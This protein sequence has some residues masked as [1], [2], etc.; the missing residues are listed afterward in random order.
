MPLESRIAS[1][2]GRR[3]AVALLMGGLLA[4]ALAIAWLQAR[5]GPAHT[6]R[7]IPTTIER[8]GP[9]TFHRPAGWLASP[10]EPGR[11]GITGSGISFTEP[12]GAQRKLIVVRLSYVRP[13][14]P[15][16]AARLFFEQIAHGPAEVWALRPR[17]RG[18]L[19]TLDGAVITPH[20]ERLLAVL[21]V[22]GQEYLGLSLSG[23]EIAPDD[24]PLLDLWMASV[25]DERFVPLRE[26][27]ALPVG[28]SIEAPPGLSA[29]GYAGDRELTRVLFHP[30]HDPRFGVLRFSSI[31]LSAAPPLPEQGT[32]AGEVLTNLVADYRQSTA[33]ERL[34]T[35]LLARYDRAVG[36]LPPAQA[37]GQFRVL[38]QSGYL[39]VLRSSPRLGIYEA[40]WG[41]TLAPEQAAQIE[42]AA[43]LDPDDRA[44]DAAG[45][46]Q[47]AAS[48]LVQ[49]LV[50]A[51][52]RPAVP[53][54]PRAVN[55]GNPEGATE[56]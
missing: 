48:V 5:G 35:H 3:A 50:G 17:R 20:D 37:Y 23:P 52:E 42:V 40:V 49:T 25:K 8:L 21:T 31:D 36:R 55:G 29:L 39:L 24:P 2:K 46:T 45:P 53:E 13:A 47:Q 15:A 43:A 7:T 34:L 51:R 18:P 10:V 27:L 1:E 28:M 41:V 4:A 14:P 16:A 6:P 33:A 56:P 9:F 19:V 12:G 44:L 11:T 30:T 54:T 38:D 26:P 22:D 32:S